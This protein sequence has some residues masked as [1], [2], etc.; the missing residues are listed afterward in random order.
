MDFLIFLFF[1]II[2]STFIKNAATSSRRNYTNPFNNS[3]NSSN[4]SD[5]DMSSFKRPMTG[6]GG[7][8]IRSLSDLKNEVVKELNSADASFNK[9]SPYKSSY[10]RSDNSSR[11]EYSN[12]S[13]QPRPQQY[14]RLPA[15]KRNDFNNH[16]QSQSILDLEM[17]DANRIWAEDHARMMEINQR[18]NESIARQHAENERLM[19][20]AASME[21]R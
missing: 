13:V 21:P 14:S 1:M 20:E 16:E 9:K 2:L 3:R 18:F 10:S 7:G 12:R 5:N 15:Q 8:T 17:S 4:G 6:S 19:R 11:G